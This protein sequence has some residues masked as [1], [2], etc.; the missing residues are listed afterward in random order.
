MWLV[1]GIGAILF[2]ILNVV[3]SFQNREAKYFRFLS[4]ALTALTVCAFY[5]DG[6][7]RVVKRNYSGLMDTMP[8]ISKALWVCVMISILINS[9]SIFKGK[10]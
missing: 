9:I 4:L 5:E 2:A 1:L 10:R 6:A 7:M 3:W 8:S